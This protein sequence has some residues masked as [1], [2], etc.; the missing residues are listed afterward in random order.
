MRSTHCAA[1]PC[2]ASAWSTLVSLSL[3]EF[4]DP[5]QQQGHGFD[6]L[7]SEAMDWL[8]NIK[9]ITL[10]SAV[11]HGLR[12]AARAR[13]GPRAGWRPP[14]TCGGWPPA[15]H[16]RGP[17]FRVVGRHP[18]HPYAIVGLLMIPFRMR[19]TASS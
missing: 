6:A 13:I 12:V 7:A 15:G 16:R 8:V 3:Y 9:F 18:V 19:L 1:S 5:Q 17:W 4:L 10:F 11:R 2:W 14:A